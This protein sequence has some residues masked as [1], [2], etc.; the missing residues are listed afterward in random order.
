MLHQSRPL[1]RLQLGGVFLHFLPGPGGRH[2]QTRLI[3]S[4]LVQ[5]DVESAFNSWY[6]IV[7]A[8]Y[9]PVLGG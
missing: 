4:I 3:E 5:P 7:L 9:L 8:V 6:A 1:I 2:L